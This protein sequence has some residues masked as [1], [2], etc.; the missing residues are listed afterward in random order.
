MSDKPTETVTFD[1]LSLKQELLDALDEVGYESPSPVQA[2]TIP[3]LLEGESIS[4]E[5][6]A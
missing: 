2:A 1:D 3:V 5:Q 6:L 4:M